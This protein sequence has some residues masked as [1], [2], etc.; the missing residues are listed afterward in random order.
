[1]RIDFLKEAEE[2]QAE[3]TGIRRQLHTH[4]EIGNHEFQTSKL[5]Q[6]FLQKNGI[7]VQTM[8]D[9]AVVGLLRGGRPGRTVAF[10]SDMDA[11]PV[12]EQTGLPFSSHEAGMMH[13]CGHDV[14]MAALLGAAKLLSKHRDQLC[15]NVKF[16]FQP[17]EEGWG[18]AKRMIGAGCMESPHVDAVFGAHVDPNLPAGQVAV[19]YGNFY[20]TSDIFTATVHGVSTHGAEPHN[21][22]D[23]IVVGAQIVMALQTIPSRRMPPAEPCVLSLGEFHCGN[24][25]SIISGEAKIVGQYRVF[26]TKNREKINQLVPQVIHGVAEANGATVDLD[27]TYGY[28]GIVNHDDATDLAARSVRQLLG[29]ENLITYREPTML[30][31][32]FGYFIEHVTGSF[33]HIGVRNPDVGAVHPLHSEKFTVDESAIPKAAALHS[34]IAFNFLSQEGPS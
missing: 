18:G 22:I 23:P 14:H 8:L 5:I 34:Q 13:A 30:T 4:P 19:K 2:I 7:E 27:I 6:E 28:S 9:T 21:G 20:A 17:D 10:R 32:D 1:M 11:L 25:F 15:G 16:F 3:L 33:Y 26:G 31:E 29:E 12:Q 24:R